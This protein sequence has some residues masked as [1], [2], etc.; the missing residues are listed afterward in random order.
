M[1]KEVTI[2]TKDFNLLSEA[3]NF[4]TK[5]DRELWGKV[6]HSISIF[7]LK[8][9]TLRLFDSDNAKRISKL[10]FNLL[11]EAINFT[12]LDKDNV[13]EVKKNI[14][15]FFLKLLTLRRKMKIL[16]RRKNIKFQSSF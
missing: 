3:I 15:I 16:G 7:F 13:K 6:K 10:H 4:T 2:F 9:L 14:S 5:S 12:T 1:G 8:L 11:S